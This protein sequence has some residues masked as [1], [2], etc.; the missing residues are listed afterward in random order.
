MYLRLVDYIL[1]ITAAQ[2]HDSV[3]IAHWVNHFLGCM[4][5]QVLSCLTPVDSYWRVSMLV[6]VV[7]IAG[8]SPGKGLFLYDVV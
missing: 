4:W 3:S 1:R 2:V 8:N 5:V 7:I 6:V